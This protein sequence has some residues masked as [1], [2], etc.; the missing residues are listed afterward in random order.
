MQGTASKEYTVKPKDLKYV[1]IPAVE[2]QI[3]GTVPEPKVT[4][5]TAVL[6]KGTDYTLSNSVTGNKGTLTFT[7]TGNYTGTVT[8]DYQIR[9][10][11]G[12]VCFLYE[13]I[14]R[15]HRLCNSSGGYRKRQGIRKRPMF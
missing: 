2:N 14:L 6:V 1:T 11:I 7:G 4:D 15:L 8:R 10:G 3:A 9:E 12:C 13:S 5:G